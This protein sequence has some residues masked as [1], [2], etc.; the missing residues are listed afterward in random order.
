MKLPVL[1][2]PQEGSKFSFFRR[3]YDEIKSV[4]EDNN[5]QQMKL[6]DIHTTFLVMAIIVYMVFVTSLITHK[7]VVLEKMNSQQPVLDL[8]SDQNQRH[9]SHL[10]KGKMSKVREV[11]T[12]T[13]TT[14]TMTTSTTLPDL[15]VAR[16][17][18]GSGVTEF[19]LAPLG[20]RDLVRYDFAT[21]DKTGLLSYQNIDLVLRGTRGPTGGQYSGNVTSQAMTQFLH[22]RGG[23]RG[24]VMM[25]PGN[26]GLFIRV[27][28]HSRIAGWR[29]RACLV[30]P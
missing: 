17:G 29:F 3:P 5:K 19:S 27:K 4:F 14:T 10:Q 1:H 13:T 8:L 30:R 6:P 15:C 2:R 23:R 7:F 18:I 26:T 24:V 9:L 25:G 28:S 20:H 11:N 21:H 16:A 12:T 22:A